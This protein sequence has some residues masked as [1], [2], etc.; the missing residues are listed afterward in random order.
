MSVEASTEAPERAYAS[1]TSP[2]ESGI[3]SQSASISWS[4]A[5]GLRQDSA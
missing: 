3:C 2:E 4:L 1:S 5:H